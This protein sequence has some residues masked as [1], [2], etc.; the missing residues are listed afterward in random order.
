MRIGDGRSG[1]GCA[2]VSPSIGGATREGGFGS[3]GGR[4][5]V[6]RFPPVGRGLVSV[7][8]FVGEF[9][10]YAYAIDRRHSLDLARTMATNTLVVMETF[11]LFFVRNTYCRR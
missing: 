7:L 1:Y 3:G 9:G 5:G 4:G 10:I 2:W 11:Y 6:K 8:F